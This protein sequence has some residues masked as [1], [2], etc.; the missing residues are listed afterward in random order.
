MKTMDTNEMKRAMQYKSDI[1][2]LLDVLLS[3]EV[4]ERDNVCDLFDLRRKLVEMVSCW[5][6]HSE[7][8]VSK[9]CEE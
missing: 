1:A 3:M 9:F 5:S 2:K 7:E 4:P 8:A 6:G